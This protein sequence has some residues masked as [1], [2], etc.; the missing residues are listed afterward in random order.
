MIIF[1]IIFVVISGFTS[2]TKVNEFEFG[3]MQDGTGKL[4]SIIYQT[5]IWLKIRNTGE[6]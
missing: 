6:K 4:V 1:S 5:K 3:K 2:E